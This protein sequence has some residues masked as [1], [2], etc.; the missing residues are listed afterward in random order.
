MG[1]PPLLETTL[2]AAV[3]DPQLATPDGDLVRR[4]TEGVTI[5]SLP[6]IE[7]ARGSITELFDPLP[8]SATCASTH[9]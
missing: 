7:D 2:A 5:R 1:Q 8:E 4:L 3:R 6:T 9:R